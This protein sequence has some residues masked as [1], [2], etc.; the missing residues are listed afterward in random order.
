[1]RA[2]FCP[3]FTSMVDYQHVKSLTVPTYMSRLQTQYPVV[4]VFD[5]HNDV[6]TRLQNAGGVSKADQ[7]LRESRFDIDRVKAQRGRF[8]GG[9]FA[10]WVASPGEDDFESLMV[11]EAYDVPL[12]SLVSQPDA[13]A[14]VMEQA[15]IL[16]RLQYLGAVRICTEKAD[17]DASVTA[18]TLTAVM[19][20]EGCEAIDDE[21]NSLDVL[22]AAGLRSLGP[23]WSRSNIYGEGVPFRFPSTP[24]IGEGLTTSG[25]ELIRRCNELGV[26]VDLSHLNW[27]G[28]LDVA[29]YSDAPLVATHSNVHAV[30]AHA[31]NLIDEQLAIIKASSGMVGLNFATAFLRGDGKMLSDVSLDQ[32]LRHLD[33]ML[34]YLGEDG[35]GLGSDF[36]GAGMPELIGDCSALPVLV[37]AMFEHGYGTQLIHK[38]CYGNWINMLKRTWKG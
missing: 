13:L 37:G 31:R 4:P 23:V 22:Y 36:D 34:E 16:I 8:A 21:F 9:F 12:P 10:M 5:G 26:L 1:M 29:Q 2:F 14:V 25:V 28:F 35:V 3:D 11:Q 33:H 24:D 38:I 6:L 20:L 27:K 32:M 30:S 18:E 7:F 19:H 15:A 17:L